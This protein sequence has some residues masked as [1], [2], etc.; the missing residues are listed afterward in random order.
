MVGT[1]RIGRVFGFDINVHWSWLVIFL[2]ITWTFATTTLEEFYPDWTSARRW[3]VGSAIAIIFFLSILTHEMSHSIVARR[4]G[5]SVS[6][7]TLFVFGGV[8]NLSQDPENSRQEFW[9]AIVGPLTS[10]AMALIFAI[11]WR[12]LLPIEE[13]AAGVARTL[14][15][16]NVALGVFNLIP[17][18]PLDGGRVLRSVFWAKKRNILDA[19][20]LASTIGQGV[21]Y[22]IMVLGGAIFILV[23]PLSGIWLFLIG[24]FLRAA[25]AASYEQL[26]VDKVLKGIPARSVARQDYVAVAP[27]MKLSQLAEE[28]VLAGHG[29]CFPVMAGEELLGIVTLSDLRKVPRQEWPETTVFRAMTP[30]AQLRTA[31][32]NDDL[33]A[34]MTLMA[35]GD[36]NQ[37]P[38]LEGRLL[39]GLIHRG[40][41]LHYIQMRQE[42]G[43][44]ATT[45]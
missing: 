38:L 28:E 26:F 40:D 27:D 2:L 45:D 21:A 36:I 34:V 32:V 43:T 4:Y 24:N 37:I 33:P 35:T 8:S 13:G 22:V 18:F 6:S 3:I 9:I 19:T 5:I 15:Y 7:I 30:L 44:G 14:A 29:R 12:V 41:V 39:L 1:F 17:G 11:A 16:I 31:G 20:R 42:M 10:F 25:S 23:N